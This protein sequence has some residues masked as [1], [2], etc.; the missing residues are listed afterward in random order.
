MGRLVGKF[1]H[2]IKT[3]EPIKLIVRDSMFACLNEIPKDEEKEKTMVGFNNKSDK[4]R[5]E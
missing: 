3:K 4:L 1:N 5:K 2:M